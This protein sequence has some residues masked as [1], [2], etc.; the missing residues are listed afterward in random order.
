LFAHVGALLRPDILARKRAVA[1]AVP[2]R[3]TLPRNTIYAKR[4]ATDDDRR[5]TRTPLSSTDAKR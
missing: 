1:A 3:R 4:G 5:A 2:P